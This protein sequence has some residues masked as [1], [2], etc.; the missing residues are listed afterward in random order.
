MASVLKG[1]RTFLLPITKAPTVGTTDTNS[2]FDLQGSFE[3]TPGY[4]FYN[5]VISILFNFSYFQGF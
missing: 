1:Y 4:I 3:M 2:L 5:N